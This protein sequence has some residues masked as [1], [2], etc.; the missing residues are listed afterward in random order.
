MA[1]DAK[2]AKDSASNV[3]LLTTHYYRENQRRGSAELLLHPDPRL[4]DV[5]VRL[6]TASQHSG[7]PWRI[8]ETNSFSGGGL[9]GVSDSFVGT[10]WTLD[11]MLLLA[12]YGCAGVNIETGV[13]QLGFVSSYSP[14]QDD[15]KGMN[16]A[17]PSY[18]GMLAF[19]AAARGCDEILPIDFDAMG[20]N[21]TAY[22]L[23]A[24]GKPRSV[25]VVNKDRAQDTQF[26]IKQLGT[27]AV[28][29]LRLTAPSAE[30]KSGITLGRSG[31]DLRGRWTAASEEHI[32]DG[33]VTVPRMSAVVLRSPDHAHV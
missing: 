18:Y 5:L 1:K 15:G 7:I 9:R 25:V 23:G 17:G 14:I 26:S 2:G 12:A 4:K 21:V 22:A 24:E 10:L 27:S 6:R 19:A 28:S 3:Q 8:C 13:N 29:V 20:I 31:V 30:S 32:Q 11:F 33:V 16:T